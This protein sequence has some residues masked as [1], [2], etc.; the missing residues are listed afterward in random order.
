MLG[1]SRACAEVGAGCA[2]AMFQLTVPGLQ[3]CSS[4]RVTSCLGVIQWQAMLWQMPSSFCLWII[5]RDCGFWPGSAV[6]C[7]P[8]A[9]LSVAQSSCSSLGASSGAGEHRFLITPHCLPTDL[10]VSLKSSGC[11]FFCA[12]FLSHKIMP[13]C[14]VASCDV[15]VWLQCGGGSEGQELEECWVRGLFHCYLPLQLWVS[16]RNPA[17]AQLAIGWRCSSAVCRESKFKLYCR[18]MS[19]TWHGGHAGQVPVSKWKFFSVGCK[20]EPLTKQPLH[21]RAGGDGCFCCDAK[22]LR[23]SL[24]VYEHVHFFKWM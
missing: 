24:C 11:Y 22:Q 2:V 18:E 21:Y 6:L 4:P 16:Y 7:H 12:A 14:L 3:G 10:S 19:C 23:N 15:G 17:L 20:A 5:K 1:F 9:S 13:W 8:S